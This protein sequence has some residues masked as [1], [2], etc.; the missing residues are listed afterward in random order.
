[1]RTHT[2]IIALLATSVIAFAACSQKSEENIAHA[3]QREG[4]STA[5]ATTDPSV[6]ADNTG[7]NKR[8][9]NDATLTTGDQSQSAADLDL[10]KKVRQAIE[11]DDT[12]SANGKNVKVITRDGMVTLR[13]PVKDENERKAIGDKATMIAGEGKVQNL[14]EV[15]R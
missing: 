6:P 9:R 2:P 14:L 10:V 12:L 3:Q 11:A 1:M 13:G 5:A 15:A 4:D 7:V 8:D